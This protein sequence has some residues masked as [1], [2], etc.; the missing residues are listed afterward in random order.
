M[1]S[2]LHKQADKVLNKV[3]LRSSSSPTD[4]TQ[5][6]S[7][8]TPTPC[9]KRGL[10]WPV[11]N[12]DPVFPFTKPGS[13]ISWICTSRRLSLLK[14]VIRQT[15]SHS[16]TDNWSPNPVPSSASLHFVPMTWNHVGL[17]TLPSK[18]SDSHATHLLA[19]NE[20]ELPDQA[21]M[22]ASFAAEQ[23]LTYIEPLR[24][25]GIRCGSPGISSAGHAVGW[26]KEFWEKIKSGG[27]DVDFWCLHWF[28]QLVFLYCV[29]IF[30]LTCLREPQVWRRIGRVL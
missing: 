1:S 17:D 20:P 9:S 7:S 13:K 16:H 22:T 6:Q 28:V 19:F 18:L 5:M 4:Q 10:C 14:P 24:K 27:G 26:L 2:F 25:Q 30:W 21:N 15:H 12:K 11:E 8:S 23:W 29:K 3:Q